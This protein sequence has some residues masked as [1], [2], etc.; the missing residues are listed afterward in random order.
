MKEN[1]F[2]NYKDKVKSTKVKND[3]DIII[4]FKTQLVKKEKIIKRFKP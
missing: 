3:S 4:Q 1:T 2:K